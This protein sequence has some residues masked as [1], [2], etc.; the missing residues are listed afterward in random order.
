MKDTQ[1]TLICPA[2]GKD[3][4]KVK[5]S[6]EGLFLDVCLKGCGG[7][8]FDNRELEKFDEKSE[9]IA[10]LVKVYEGK[11]F[12][13]A[14]QTI[15]RVCPAC[16]SNFVKN[17]TSIRR[18]IEIDD[19][20]SCGGKFLDHG[21]LEK[22]RGEYENTRER[23]NDVVQCFGLIAGKEAFETESTR[24]RKSLA[25]KLFLGLTGLG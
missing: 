10:N 16:G 2:C 7:I 11:T 1:E 19:C 14:D 23:V 3:M 12:K 25:N 9:C 13:E 21:E 15:G 5:M 6:G 17:F 24:R 4:D 20:Y 18:E 8:Y 22:M